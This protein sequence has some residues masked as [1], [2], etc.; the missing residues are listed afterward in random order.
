MKYLFVMMAVLLA[1]AITAAPAQAQ[2]QY[3]NGYYGQPQN[4][5]GVLSPQDQQQ[6]DKYYSKWVD[7]T[8]KNDQDD[9]AGNARHMQ[10][11]MTRYNIPGNVPF[12]QITSNPAPYAAGYP[13]GA[14][15]NGAYPNGAYPNGAYPNG[16]YPYPANG[17]VRLSPDDQKNFDKA[18]GKWVDATR[19]NDQDDIA[20]NA[21]KMQEIMARYNIPPNV[22]F[23]AIATN[24]YAAG[25][26]GAA[27]YPYAQPAQRLSAKDQGD[28]DNAYRKWVDAR[29]KRDMDDVDK[30]AR[31][32]EQIMAR[33]N[34]PANV[35]FDQIA[36]AGG[37]YR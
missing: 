36:S 12:D 10:D 21:G 1:V 13:N 5:H 18:Y 23:A 28:F 15:P 32:M 30:N 16:A 29:R 27:P 22:P 3:P 2:A 33:Y 14:Y 17:Q 34:I 9:I 20:N 19:K 25:P 4:W 8:R 7:A 6:F 35:P 24:G 37:V 11:I 26:N 31:K